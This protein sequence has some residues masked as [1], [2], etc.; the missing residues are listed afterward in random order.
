MLLLSNLARATGVAIRKCD[1][2]VS[3]VIDNFVAFV[4]LQALGQST[5][6]QTCTGV[7]IGFAEAKPQSHTSAG[8][9]ITRLHQLCVS[10]LYTK[11]GE[12][13][14]G[15][16]GSTLT[17]SS[18]NKYSIGLFQSPFL[19]MVECRYSASLEG[20]LGSSSMSH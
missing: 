2:R 18:R 14:L 8:L 5:R 4:E 19:S 10:G 9:A 17:R 11:S 7:R 6:R 20:I 1:N 15:L 3:E 16:Q 12:S 13:P